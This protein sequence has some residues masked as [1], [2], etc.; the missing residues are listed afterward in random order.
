S[1][2]EEELERIKLQ[3]IAGIKHAKSDPGYLADTLFGKIVFGA[4]P[5]SLEPGGTEESVSYLSSDHLKTFYQ[6]NYSS[7]NAFI[8]AAGDISARELGNIL[9]EK[10]ASWN[11]SEAE[12]NTS[13]GLELQRGTRV[14]LVKKEGAVQSAIR[15]GHSGIARNHPDYIPIYVMN[16]LLGGYF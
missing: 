6:D 5:Y 1:F 3:R 2:A 10:L 4:H 14:S 12:H 7:K 15:L 16:V 9:N 8:I 11:K 13:N